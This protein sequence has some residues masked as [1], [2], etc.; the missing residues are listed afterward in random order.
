[1]TRPSLS[2]GLLRVNSRMPAVASTVLLALCLALL[3]T[4][5]HCVKS[6]TKASYFHLPQPAGVA[7]DALGDVYGLVGTNGT[8]VKWTAAGKLLSTTT[9]LPVGYLQGLALDG[10]GNQYLGGEAV[11]RVSAATD[12]LSQFQTPPADGSL[13]SVPSIAADA[14]SGRVYACDE[15]NGRVAVFDHNGLVLSFVDIAVPTAV[16]ADSAGNVYVIEHLSNIVSKFGPTGAP[17]QYF[18]TSHPSMAY[19]SGLAV[20]SLGN[21]FVADQGNNR[22]VQ[23]SKAGEFTAVF[24]SPA[25]PLG[26]NLGQVAVDACGAVYVADPGNQ[27]IVKWVVDPT[28]TYKASSL[29]VY[30]SLPS[31]FTYFSMPQPSGVSVDASGSVH[32]LNAQQGSIVT[33]SQ[34]A[35]ITNIAFSAVYGD[36]LAMDACGTAY[37]GSE[38]SIT[39]VRTSGAVVPFNVPYRDEFDGD[40][41][42]PGQPYVDSS[43]GNVYIPVGAYYVI[44][45]FS[46]VG[47]LLSVN[48][49]PFSSACAVAY[50]SAGNLYVVDSE[51]GESSNVFKLSA[52]GVTVL[53]VFNTS[54]PQLSSPSGLAVDSSGTVFVS[55]TGNNRVVEFN[56]H[57]AVVNIL[58]TPYPF[59]GP[60]GQLALDGCGNSYVADPSSDRIVKFTLNTSC[61]VQTSSPAL[62]AYCS[63]PSPFAFYYMPNIAGVAVDPS[64]VLHG[65]NGGDSSVVAFTASGG[66]QV[67]YIWVDR[68]HLAH[69]RRVRPAVRLGQRAAVQGQ[70]QRRLAGAAARCRLQL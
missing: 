70:R 9:P 18:S 26:F 1:M 11:Y 12:Q 17:L 43:T 69:H 38:A 2:A 3:S 6:V 21:V 39:Q 35:A 29:P 40:I 4:L 28:C 32:G 23:F 25:S 30:C 59:L 50:D 7:V 15:D 58:V 64:G 41:I 14:G 63:A 62:P 10:C 51:Y 44:F 48:Q 53:L 45:V 67:S 46:P 34:S 16:S 65:L 42:R 27:R 57:G 36:S 37:V 22:V 8:I 20:G 68:R 52:D 19:P 60:T 49:L 55:D 13:E 5:A 31:L 24:T 47:L 56:S 54:N 61:T 33:F 66:R